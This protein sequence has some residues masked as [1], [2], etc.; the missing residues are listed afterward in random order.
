MGEENYEY[1]DAPG[2]PSVEHAKKRAKQKKEAATIKTFYTIKDGK[3]IIMLTIKPNGC[4]SSYFGNVLKIGKDVLT[5]K[6]KAWKAKGQ[7]LEPH[8][9]EAKVS[10]VIKQLQKG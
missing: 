8:E 4:Y 2:L 5:I 6:Q 7:W 1:G 10:E 9:I 3:K